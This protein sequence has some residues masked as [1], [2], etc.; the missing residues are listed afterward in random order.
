MTS[1]DVGV[2]RSWKNGSARADPCALKRRPARGASFTAPPVALAI[3][4]PRVRRP[5]GDEGG[6][7]PHDCHR[8][9]A[10]QH[11]RHDQLF[12]SLFHN[13]SPE[14]THCSAAAPAR[15]AR[16]TEGYG[17]MPSSFG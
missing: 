3:A 12:Y 8:D 7:R 1:S 9:G 15:G 17:H 4:L 5:L 6:E 14:S 11:Q 13:V 16:V 2:A 10:E